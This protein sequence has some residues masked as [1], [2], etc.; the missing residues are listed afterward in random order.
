MNVISSSVKKRGVELAPRSLKRP[1]LSSLKDEAA[2]SDQRR[3]DHQ[4]V[5][6]ATV[7][8]NRSKVANSAVDKVAGCHEKNHNGTP[9]AESPTKETVRQPASAG[10]GGRETAALR[11]GRAAT[12]RP[13]AK[14]DSTEHVASVRR[15][16]DDAPSID[17]ARTNAAPPREVTTP[18]LD[19]ETRPGYAAADHGPSSLSNVA[20]DSGALETAEATRARRERT[21][22]DSESLQI[23]P[24]AVRMGDLTRDL[25]QGRKS[26]KYAEFKRI[27]AARRSRRSNGAQVHDGSVQQTEETG[28]A[29]PQDSP[30]GVAVSSTAHDRVVT[31][32]G[33]SGSVA[34]ARSHRA[35]GGSEAAIARRFEDDDVDDEDGGRAIAD[36][37]GHNNDAAPPP[38]DDVDED[39][40]IHETAEESDGDDDDDDALVPSAT[41]GPQLRLVNGKLVIDQS[42]LH[43]DRFANSARRNANEPLQYV[44]ENPLEKRL[45]SSSYGKKRNTDKWD[46]GSTEAFYDALGQW[47]TDFEM[48]SQLFPNRTRRQIKSKFVMEE[49]RNG[50]RITATLKQPKSMNLAEYSTAANIE[51]RDVEV[52]EQELRDLKDAYE[53]ETLDA[54]SKREELIHHESQAKV[55]AQSAAAD[56]DKKRAS[57]SAPTISSTM[58]RQGKKAGPIGRGDEEVLG[59]V[60]TYNAAEDERLRRAMLSSSEED[61]DDS[62]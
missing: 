46:E 35:N 43:V 58:A 40:E 54:Q 38:P 12:G 6:I 16:R 15:Q 24:K 5:D 31:S 41:V 25:R 20:E 59:S 53:R 45:N 34:C 3:S 23:D 19:G 21:P 39:D 49:R 26:S 36:I 44:E 7:V 18:D 61:D 33:A 47:G 22:E 60:E 48:I 30:S 55:D 14:P 37:D 29:A 11:G 56:P 13:A 4:Y 17:E 27:A 51:V 10:Q 42:T 28:V 62:D 8:Q 50:A 2:P 32:P 9:S 52:V 57:A 1:R